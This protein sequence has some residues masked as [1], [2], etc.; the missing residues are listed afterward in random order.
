MYEGASEYVQENY[1]G[2]EYNVR[3]SCLRV[4][5]ADFRSVRPCTTSLSASLL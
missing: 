1:R 5:S 2:P 4:G 3:I